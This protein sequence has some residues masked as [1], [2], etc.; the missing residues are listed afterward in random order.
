MRWGGGKV[1]IDV[2]SCEHHNDLRF[3]LAKIAEEEF[4]KKERS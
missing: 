2:D 3:L 4:G 1:Y